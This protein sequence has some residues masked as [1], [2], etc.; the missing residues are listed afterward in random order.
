M[1]DGEPGVPPGWTGVGARPSTGKSAKV[2]RCAYV[3]FVPIKVWRC[4][5][6]EDLNELS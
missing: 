3:H 5:A 4:L 6:S 2:D 1:I